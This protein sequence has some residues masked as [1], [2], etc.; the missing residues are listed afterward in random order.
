MTNQ[1]YIKSLTQEETKYYLGISSLNDIDAYNEAI[2]EIALEEF[3][4][5]FCTDCE[6]RFDE[7]CSICEDHEKAPHFKEYNNVE[8][9]WLNNDKIKDL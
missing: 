2:F 1:E 6:E 5:T 4:D 7:D 8:L 3:Q 9:W